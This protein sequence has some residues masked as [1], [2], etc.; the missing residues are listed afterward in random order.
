M[1][2][3]S[4]LCPPGTGLTTRYIVD[5]CKTEVLWSPV[6][7]A[8][9]NMLGGRAF[10]ARHVGNLLRAHRGVS[11]DGLFIHRAGQDQ[12]GYARWTVERSPL[13]E[14]QLPIPDRFVEQLGPEE[15]LFRENVRTFRADDPDAPVDRVGDY[16][17]GPECLDAEVA[18]ALAAR[19][20]ATIAAP[21][22][23]ESECAES[24]N[25]A[26][27][28]DTPPALPEPD[29]RTQVRAETAKRLGSSLS[30]APPPPLPP[31]SFKEPPDDGSE[32]PRRLAVT[33]PTPEYPRRSRSERRP[34][35]VHEHAGSG[36]L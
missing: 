25:A 27:I 18:A 35:G 3:L 13:V 26:G 29:V 7:E 4:R 28:A 9:Q 20:T 36:L 6:L 16:R 15:E 14:P 17:T 5:K 11:V 2:A 21:G 30:A 10:D 32:A 12:S 23:A 8:L 24:G 22:S 34:Q 33:L 19:N 31:P 1:R